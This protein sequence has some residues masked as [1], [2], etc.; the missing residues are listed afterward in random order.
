MVEQLC[1]VKGVP[2]DIESSLQQLHSV[3]NEGRATLSNREDHGSPANESVSAVEGHQSVLLPST[4][5]SH[6]ATEL[7]EID[8]SENFIDGMGA[9]KFTN[10]EDCEFFCTP[11][12][13]NSSGEGKDPG[14]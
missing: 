7:G 4:L 2:Q 12:N 9:M 13:A 6:D 14:S 5:E 8:V 11:Q 10:E 1:I 3:Q